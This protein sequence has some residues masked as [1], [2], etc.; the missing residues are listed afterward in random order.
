[1]DLGAV[2]AV[3]RDLVEADAARREPRE[4][5]QPQAAA[6]VAVV[7]DLRR[8]GRTWRP[9]GRCRRAGS[10]GCRRCRPGRRRRRRTA[11][12]TRS[13]G[14]WLITMRRPDVPPRGRA[15]RS[16]RTCR[17]AYSRD[18]ASR[19]SASR[20]APAGW[21]PGSGSPRVRVQV[22][23]VPS[24]G[25]ALQPSAFSR[26]WRLLRPVARL[27]GGGDQD[28][29]QDGEDDDERS[30]GAGAW[31]NRM[32]CRAVVSR[33][34][35]SPTATAPRRAM[36]GRPVPLTIGID[37]GG[38]KV[39]GGVVDSFGT[40]ADQPAPA[41]PGRSVPRRRGH[42]RRARR[43]PERGVRR[44]GGRHRRGRV[45][46]RRPRDGAVLARTSPG[47]TSRCATR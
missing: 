13:S 25:P 11:P 36:I 33:A 29:R 21:R 4:V 3:L 7:A 9:S 17:S 39:L 14:V 2:G 18:C 5:V 30:A 42:H 1:M 16:Q 10:A 40:R 44:R 37:I 23:T 6:G 41:H 26:R 32:T 47:A 28:G 45:R 20:S 43:H 35:P 22:P 31:R 46:R 8:P 34:C 24:A 19:S 15:G 38:T 12:A 27:P